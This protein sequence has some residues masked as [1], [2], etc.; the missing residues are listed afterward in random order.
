MMTSHVMAMFH[1]VTSQRGK[2]VH[3][4]L[5][6]I[7]VG[8]WVPLSTP[9]AAA[10]DS[11]CQL[12]GGSHSPGTM[13][14]Y[15]LDTCRQARPA[16]NWFSL[17]IAARGAGTVLEMGG[18]KFGAKRRNFFFMCPIFLQCPSS[19]LGTCRLLVPCGRCTNIQL[20]YTSCKCRPRSIGTLVQKTLWF[21]ATSRNI[22]NNILKRQRSS[23]VCYDTIA[24][25]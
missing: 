4:W 19:L 7:R 16:C 12:L 21:D 15:H 8:R 3:R 13:V 10:V 25:S 20:G 5:N 6:D 1:S 24:P 9:S 17:E 11:L 22:W 23:F 18:H 2:N 14:P